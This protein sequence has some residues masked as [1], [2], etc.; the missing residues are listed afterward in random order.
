MIT[1]HGGSFG[2]GRNS[3]SY[4]NNIDVYEADAIEVDIYKNFGILYIS[5]LPAPFT[6]WK[7]IRLREVFKLVKEKEIKVNCDLKQHGIIKDV[8]NLAKSMGMEDQLIFTGSVRESDYKIIDCGEVWL[9]KMKGISYSTKNV[10]Q[11]KA[12]LESL[13]NPRFKGIN[14][15]YR[16]LSG[17]FIEA[18]KM[19]NVPISAFTIDN[20]NKLL[21]L[22]PIID[23]NITTNLPLVARSILNKS[24]KEN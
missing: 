1:A 10:P 24:K 5:H 13:N 7:K 12:R 23:G 18:C 4:L 14:I 19:Y 22:V 21:K 8:I 20:V 2:S 11:I 15:N 16:K 17:K 6:C 9:N 3:H